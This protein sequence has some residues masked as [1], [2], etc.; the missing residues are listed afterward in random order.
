MFLNMFLN[1]NTVNYYVSSFMRN[2]SI[3]I[4]IFLPKYSFDFFVNIK[5]LFRK[6]LFAVASKLLSNILSIS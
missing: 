1:L 3:K 6:I 4:K 2:L 5:N